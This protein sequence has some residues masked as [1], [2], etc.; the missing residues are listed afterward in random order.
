MF[1]INFPGIWDNPWVVGSL[2]A[3]ALF[4][5][6][7]LAVSFASKKW[8]FTGPLITVFSLAS[9]FFAIVG[10]ALW[11]DAASHNQKE[12][13]I[14]K[15]GYDSVTVKGSHFIANLDGAYFSGILVHVEDNKYI[16]VG[17]E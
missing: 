7:L 16:I 3:W 8:S 1:E 2:A 10:G 5:V 15:Q 12:M 6:L 13:A 11:Y 9:G 14:E 17:K 4:I